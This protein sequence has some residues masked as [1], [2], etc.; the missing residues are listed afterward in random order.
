MRDDRAEQIDYGVFETRIGEVI[1]A[2]SCKGL[3]WLGFMVEGYKGN[4]L[5]RLKRFYPKAELRRD[6]ARLSG[7]MEEVLQAWDED[8]F[9]RIALDLQ[10]TAFQIS[11]WRALMDIP[12]GE[13][14]TY[15]DIARA[16]GKP[17]ASRAV[18]SAVG[19]NPV[20]LVVPCHR[21]VQA[22]GGLGNYGWGVDIKAD[23][24]RE[25]G[26]GIVV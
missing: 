4:G 5:D 18:G 11:V 25:E 9:D 19:E 16:I 6:D 26:A 7:L 22:S 15:S 2:R 8:R 17:K 23:L 10:G 14:Y 12:K 1:I 3:C 24:L 20:S 13:V 21:V